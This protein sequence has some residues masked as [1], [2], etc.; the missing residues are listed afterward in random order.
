MLFRSRRPGIRPPYCLKAVTPLNNNL[1]YDVQKRA[2]AGT[3]ATFRAVVSIYLCY[4]AYLV[5]KGLGGDSPI[6]TPVG[7]AIALVFVA[8][9]VGFGFYTWKH[10][11]KDLA[12]AKLTPKEPQETPEEALE[13]PD[14]V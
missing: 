5:V 2:R 12:D 13:E 10:Y 4:M 7:W 9:A 6:P 14:D 3:R 8:A 1:E 11:R